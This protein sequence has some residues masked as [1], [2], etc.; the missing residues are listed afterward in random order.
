MQLNVNTP[1]RI[2][3]NQTKIL[4]E[5]A[6]NTSQRMLSASLSPKRSCCRNT[7][8]SCIV[9]FALFRQKCGCMRFLLTCNNYDTTTILIIGNRQ[10]VYNMN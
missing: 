10:M 9:V 5:T 8:A 6:K 1:N 7:T 2:E 3:T 4:R